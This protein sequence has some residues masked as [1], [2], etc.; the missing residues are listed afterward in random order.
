MSY[1]TKCVDENHYPPAKGCNGNRLHLVRVI[2][3]EEAVDQINRVEH[4]READCQCNGC[5]QQID[6]KVISHQR[7]NKG[8]DI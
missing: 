2:S 1:R 8:A 5:F 6:R 3:A 4:D 7:K